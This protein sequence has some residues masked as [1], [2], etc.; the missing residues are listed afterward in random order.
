MYKITLL[1]KY[2]AK[3]IARYKNMAEKTFI[4]ETSAH[5]I[6]VTQEALDYLFDGDELKV[7]KELSQPGQ[8]ASDKKL[9]II[10]HAQIKNKETGEITIKDNTIKGMRILGPVRKENQVE[11]SMT[12]ARSLKANVPVRESGDLEGSAPVTL[13][14]PLNGKKVD[15]EK[16]MI[17]AKRHIHMT[18]EDAKNFGVSN[19]E[20]VSVKI[21]SSNGRSAILGDTVIRVSNKYALAMHIDTDES[22]AI[23]GA[24]SGVVGEIVKVEY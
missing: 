17:I 6:H 16:G 2:C 22:N 10:Y 8:F 18:E 1:K 9:D 12:E 15:C 24:A 11:I 19:G 14:N 5:H 7:V 21:K 3:I 13:Y 20:I 4:V 23:G